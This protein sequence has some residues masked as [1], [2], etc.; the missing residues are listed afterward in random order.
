LAEAEITK[1]ASNTYETARVS[2][3]N[4]LMNLCSHLPGTNVDN[5]TQALHHRFAKR[6]FRGSVPYGGPC[7]PRDNRALAAVLDSFGVPAEIPRAV[8]GFNESHGVELLRRILEVSAVDSTIGIVGMAYK[9]GIPYIDKSFGVGLARQLLMAS[10]RVTVWDPLALDAVREDLQAN[11]E[12]SSSLSDLA[13]RS[14]VI[15]ITQPYAELRTRDWIGRNNPIILDPWRMFDPNEHW[16]SG[17]YIPLGMTSFDAA[18][19]R[20]DERLKYLME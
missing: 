10:R 7:W 8:D 15:V 20:M 18:T 9:V 5:I 2:F 12:Y 6:F 13:Q 19:G 4:M 3:V 16:C 11:V 17:R 14:S 1:L